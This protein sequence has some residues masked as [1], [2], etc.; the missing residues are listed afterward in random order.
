MGRLIIRLLA[1]PLAAQIYW[2]NGIL[3][4]IGRE[5]ILLELL[6][7]DLQ[8]KITVRTELK[9]EQMSN[10]S[11]LIFAAVDS[12]VKEWYNLK[13]CQSVQSYPP[14]ENCS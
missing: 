13:V 11:W 12:L 9:G 14:T 2:R 8:L 3:A 7:S 1:F 10:L 4:H 6:P 5:R